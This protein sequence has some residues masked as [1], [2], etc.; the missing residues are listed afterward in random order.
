M[1]PRRLATAAAFAAAALQA[2]PSLAHHSFAMFDF[3]RTMTLKGVVKEL[4]WTNPHVILWVE[5]PSAAGA[6]PEIWSAELTSPG[7]LTRNGWSKRTLKPGDKVLV[8]ISPLRDGGK[9]GG[10]RRAVLQETGQV[11]TSD[12]RNQGRPSS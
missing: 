9:G 7:N 8:D 2:A 1:T 10:F 5:A 6:M 12:L 11:F 3:S 4:Q